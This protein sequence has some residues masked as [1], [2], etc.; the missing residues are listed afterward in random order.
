MLS[1]FITAQPKISTN[2]NNNILKK[3]ETSNRKINT[4]S[5]GE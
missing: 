4:V 1:H 3:K 5:I 2:E